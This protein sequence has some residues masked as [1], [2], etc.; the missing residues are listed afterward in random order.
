MTDG[1]QKVLVDA[2]LSEIGT[3]QKYNSLVFEL[4]AEVNRL[5]LTDEE[6]RAIEWC[7]EQWAGINRS[8]T[9]RNLLERLTGTP[10]GT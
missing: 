5:K 9:L 4:Q 3:A 1:E 7:I 10:S 8:T 2:M 6:R